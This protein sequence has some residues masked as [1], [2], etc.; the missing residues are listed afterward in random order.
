MIS[1]VNK[2]DAYTTDTQ[3]KEI[4]KTLGKDDFLRLLVMQ[5]RFQDPLKPM[6]NTEFTAQLAQFSSLDKLSSIS[7]GISSLSDSQGRVN[8]VQSVSYI[9][10]E[11]KASGNK[12]YLG[13][14]T[15]SAV[16]GYTLSKDMSEVT[17]HIFDM[18]GKEIRTISI[19]QQGAGA[20]SAVWD[21]RNNS[22]DPV[23]SGA[24]IFSVTAKDI[25]GKESDALTNVDGIVTSIS[26]RNGSPYLMVGG[27]GVPASN[28][29][30]VK[31]VGS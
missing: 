10:K 15:H 7:D 9:G 28:I 29:I 22:G 11:V 30:E 27:I 5:M 12:V 26:F 20:Q 25:E 24:Y 3:T 2:L 31:E 1:T 6:E 21:G 19:G 8:N 13:E 4:K 18:D 23:S 14:D 16:I 17:G